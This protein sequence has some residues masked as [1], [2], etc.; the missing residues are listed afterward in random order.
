MRGAATKKNQL[1]LFLLLGG[2][3][4]MGGCAV[5]CQPPAQTPFTSI[6]GTPWRLVSTTDPTVTTLN[7]F[8]FT[9][10]TFAVAF[11]GTVQKVVNNQEYDTPILTFIWNIQTNN[12]TSGQI[13]VQFSTVPDNSNGNNSGSQPAQQPQTGPVVTYNYT[14]NNELHLTDTTMGYYYRYIPFVGIVDPDSTC[15]F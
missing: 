1:L 10:L 5:P 12:S 2:V 6:T 14:L 3:L 11:T 15:T 4:W 8:T 7:R 13:S 9:I